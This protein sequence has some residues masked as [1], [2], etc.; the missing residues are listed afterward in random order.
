MFGAS[1]D[2]RALTNTFPKDDEMFKSLTI[3]NWRQFSQVQLDFH[4]RLTVLTGANGTGKTTILN[5]L[6]KHFGWPSIFAATPQRTERGDLSYSS[7]FWG[8]PADQGDHQRVGA[9]VY[10]DNQERDLRVPVDWA[11]GGTYTINIHQNP[12]P[13]LGLHI[14][15]H[16]PVF[17]YRAIETLSLKPKTQQQVF[18]EYSSEIRDRYHGGS[19][20][21]ANVS[22]KERL[23]FL[24]A[25]GYGNRAVAGNNTWVEEFEG[26]EEVLR[27]LLPRNLG[28]ENIQIVGQEVLLKTAS[29]AFALDAASGGVGAVMDLGWQIYNALPSHDAPFVVTIDEPENHL[30]PRMQKTIMP[31]LLR[32]FPQCQFIIATHN[33]LIVGSVPASNVYVFDYNAE[34]RVITTY[35]ETANRSGTS[36]DILRDVLGL[37][38]T[39]PNWVEETLHGILEKHFTVEA[40][41]GALDRLRDELR[42]V[43]LLQYASQT[44]VLAARQ[45]EPHEEDH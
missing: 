15:S 40:E 21:T 36:N 23:M 35:L 1:H 44:T 14:A 11:S 24:A 29:G 18:N 25:L 38:F 42:G 2:P 45:M 41:E 20:R 5:I 34:R 32:A 4:G 39:M 27:K 8:Q 31:D 16:R 43:G 17:T 3:T 22:M 26:F 19:S 9:I 12:V 13:V 33:P 28:F 37:E 10:L 30:H 7:D 6:S